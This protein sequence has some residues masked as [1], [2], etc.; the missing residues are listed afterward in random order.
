MI[1]S[2]II[3]IS[4]PQ[5]RLLEVPESTFGGQKHHQNHDL[6]DFWGTNGIPHG[7]KEIAKK[8]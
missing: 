5:D 8:W 6:Y 2:P 7:T 3:K 4:P 1:L